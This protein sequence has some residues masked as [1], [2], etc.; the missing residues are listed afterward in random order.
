[1]EY[2]TVLF[3]N[4]NDEQ[5]GTLHNLLKAITGMNPNHY[6]KY[7]IH[8][9]YDE[10]AKHYIVE[11]YNSKIQI[12]P[13][14]HGVCHLRYST[15]R[16]EIYLEQAKNSLRYMKYYEPLINVIKTYGKCINGLVHIKTL[17]ENDI[18]NG[19][20]IVEIANDYVYYM[21][22]NDDGKTYDTSKTMKWSYKSNNDR[23]DALDLGIILTEPHTVMSVIDTN[24][25]L[26]GL[27]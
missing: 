9:T 16:G 1:M 13:L 27:I 15:T 14:S 24:D 23:F 8:M 20:K 21:K 11:F 22:P 18:V 2:K 5:I 26:I 4:T 12:Q 10:W 25:V 6:A 7:G 19:I 17:K 3:E